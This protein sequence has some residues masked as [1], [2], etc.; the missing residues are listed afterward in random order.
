MKKLLDS[1]KGNSMLIT[2]GILLVITI[3][4]LI[5]GDGDPEKVKDLFQAL[6]KPL[7]WISGI[8]GTALI[9]HGAAD[10][11]KG[12]AEVCPHYGVKKIEDNK[13]A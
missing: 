6:E 7:L 13:E 2:Q 4:V 9:A 8:G 3:A 10:I 11:G 12:K 1:K 5:I